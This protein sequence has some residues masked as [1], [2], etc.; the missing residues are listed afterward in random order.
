MYIRQQRSSISRLYCISLLTAA[1]HQAP[2]QHLRS[3]KWYE[4]LLAGHVGFPAQRPPPKRRRVQPVFAM[5]ELSLLDA[6]PAVASV[7]VARPQ[8]PAADL[9]QQELSESDS[10]ARNLEYELRTETLL[11]G[12]E[13]TPRHFLRES[14]CFS[15]SFGLVCQRQTT[16]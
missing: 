7:A 5:D 13:T 6:R 15:E 12:P 8:R 10:D 4:E 16:Q 11:A 1:V 2:V 9:G 3:E 14:A